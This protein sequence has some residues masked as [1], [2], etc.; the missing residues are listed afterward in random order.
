MNVSRTRLF[1]R[2]M[3]KP[4]AAEPVRTALTIF[5][6]ALGVAVVLAIDLAAATDPFLRLGGLLLKTVLVELP[7]R[8]NSRLETYLEVIRD[9]AG[10]GDRLDLPAHLCARAAG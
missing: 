5:A 2:L 6:V 9:H 10:G 8:R 4:L 7:P 3:I 1:W